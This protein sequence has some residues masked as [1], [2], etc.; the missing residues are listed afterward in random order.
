VAAAVVL[1]AVLFLWRPSVPSTREGS[2]VRRVLL[3]RDEC[4]H[5]WAKYFDSTTY[6]IHGAQ[7]K[8]IASNQFSL[9]GR[10]T[11][12][13]EFHDCQRLIDHSEPTKYLEFAAVFAREN[14]SEAL[15]SR[16]DQKNG[17]VRDSGGRARLEPSGATPQYLADADIIRDG[18][19]VAQVVSD[20]DYP[21]LGIGRGF[22]CMYLI[23]KGAKW[24]GVMV[25]VGLDEK[26]CDSQAF[27]P[28][29][30]I[31]P[32]WVDAGGIGA[33]PD[34][35]PPVARWD[36]DSR[37]AEHIIGI[38]CD[39]RWCDVSGR[40]GGKG[41]APAG[42]GNHPKQQ[43]IKGWYDEQR[44]AEYDPTTKKVTGPGSPMGTVIPDKNLERY[45][46]DDTFSDQSQ[47][48]LP[49]AH[50][51]MNSA[52]P[53]YLAKYGFE[54]VPSSKPTTEMLHISLCKGDAD[55]CGIPADAATLR[56]KCVNPTGVTK[57]LWF[58]KYE[59]GANPP[60]FYCVVYR[61]HPGF[62]I[63]AVVR[64]RWRAD[65]E[66]IWISCPEGCCETDAYPS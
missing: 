17:F 27:A 35:V 30:G 47:T 22:N 5:S 24:T 52:S 11:N 66:T 51:A 41:E 29:M 48:W 16:K 20:M 46:K 33:N 37:Y 65:D 58:A 25:Y 15:A 43:R 64:W 55:R 42:G 1:A 44:L 4:P 23:G 14:L 7:P 54:R 34:D 18:I 36:F 28:G 56:L 49:V 12:I 40:Q 39:D 6:E 61:G 10:L 8:P 60:K 3:D 57:P 2:E 26:K 9:P 53:A 63:P 19:A 13:P 59:F 45:L 38:K 31:K 21:P 32:L 62:Q 50:V